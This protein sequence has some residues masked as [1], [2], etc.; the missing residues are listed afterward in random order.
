MLGLVSTP[1][2]AME[3][4]YAQPIERSG[5]AA[6][7]WRALAAAALLSLLVGTA[8]S[9]GFAAKRESAQPAARSAGSSQTRLSSMPAPGSIS[10]ALGAVDHAYWVS[11]SSGG[12]Y[13]ALSSPQSLHTRFGRSGVA[14]STGKLQLG[15]NLRDVGY[16][17]ALTAVGNGAPSARSNRVA[18]AHAGLT[19]WY[20]NGPRGLE[21]GFTVPRAPA[22]EPRG[23]L[24]LSLALS[25]D[26]HAAT[27][28]GGRGIVFRHGASMLRYT[29]LSATDATGR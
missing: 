23:A 20:V 17:R 19:E 9:G 14:L 24:T 3:R 10:A 13:R 2:A 6:F 7:P 1:R 12:G 26:A 5:R 18:Y 8:L 29:A 28:D 25:G 11:A 15:L 27:A 22:I 4:P 21:Q 16:G